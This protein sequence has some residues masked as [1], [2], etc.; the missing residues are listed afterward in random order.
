MKKLSK[1]NYMSA[2]HISY[3]TSPKVEHA[4]YKITV[5]FFSFK[6]SF[7]KASFLSFSLIRRGVPVIYITSG[8]FIMEN[9]QSFSSVTRH[10]RPWHC[11]QKPG[12]PKA[13][14][15]A[16]SATT[17]K[18]PAPLREWHLSACQR[19][20]PTKPPAFRYLCFV[21]NFCKECWAAGRI[22]NKAEII[23]DTCVNH[24]S[25]EENTST[26]TGIMLCIFKC[27]W[28]ILLTNHWIA[29]HKW[30]IG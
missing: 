13:F 5:C 29:K 26:P 24:M 17:S 23:L 30:C 27:S 11:R 22:C 19:E 3:L 28:L 4:N 16:P 21:G 8:N 2:T 15:V 10:G 9:P 6:T 1:V 7:S 25:K 18:R 14:T 20:S 12:R